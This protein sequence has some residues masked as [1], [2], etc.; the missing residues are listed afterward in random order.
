MLTLNVPGISESCI[1][2]KIKLNFYFPTFLW[3]L[4]RLYEGLYG[5]HKT[6]WGTRKTFENKKFN[7]IFS[8]RPGLG[9]E[10][11]SQIFQTWFLI[12]INK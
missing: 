12:S 3:C 9:R 10:G 7:L 5:P 4:K 2:I 1:E 11:F 6:F 8:H